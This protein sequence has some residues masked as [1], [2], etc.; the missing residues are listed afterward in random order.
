MLPP[1]FVEPLPV[2]RAMMMGD[3][4]LY[5]WHTSAPV[6][7][8]PSSSATSTAHVALIM[9]VG[10]GFPCLP[11]RS[12]Q[13]SQPWSWQILGAIPRCDGD[14]TAAVGKLV[15]LRLTRSLHSTSVGWRPFTLSLRG[16]P[17]A[18][19][20]RELD[21]VVYGSSGFTGK[22]V[23]RYLLESVHHWWPLVSLAAASTS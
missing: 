23:A 20:K 19:M 15:S 4:T 18:A 14:Y 1:F 16:I 3:G 22:L 11:G 12:A 17:D 7:S 6:S 5:S 10:C 13:W 9:D 21:I 2:R 8:S